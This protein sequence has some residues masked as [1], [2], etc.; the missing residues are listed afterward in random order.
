MLISPTKR[1]RISEKDF[2]P[3]GD[4]SRHNAPQRTPTTPIRASYLSPTKS[5][6]ARSHPH[7]VTRSARYSLTEPR[8]RALRDEVLKR[9][10]SNASATMDALSHGIQPDPTMTTS[11]G[12]PIEPQKS[13]SD[14]ENTAEAVEQLPGLQISDSHPVVRP[15]RPP[16][17]E[18]QPVESQTHDTSD[19]EA[20]LLPQFIM[21][22]L[23][24]RQ[25]QPAPATSRPARNEPDLP[26]TPVQLG[27]DPAPG[28]PK[29]LASSS[30]PRG[31]RSGSGRH[32]K[33]MRGDQVPGTSSPL[34]F[35]AGTR[36]VQI[37]EARET[38][39]DVVVE[40]EGER[41][42]AS[43]VIEESGLEPAAE[44]R[45][46]LEEKQRVL[47]ILQAQLSE[48]KEES[49]KLEA[50]VQ[51]DGTSRED[52]LSLLKPDSTEEGSWPPKFE[53]SLDLGD[54]AMAYLTL[55]AP[56]NVRLSS[57]TDTTN[58]GGRTK[59]VHLLTVT[60][61]P[62]WP[63][64]VFGAVLEVTVDA[65]DARV[66]KIQCKGL[67]SGRRRA[68]TAN[69]ALRMWIDQRLGSELHKL[70]VGGLIWSI[71]QYFEQC[72]VRA[73]VL[74]R[75][76]DR[77]NRY[78]DSEVPGYGDIEEPGYGDIEEPDDGD[79]KAPP[80]TSQQVTA[81]I[82]YLTMSQ[83]EIEPSSSTHQTGN[84]P[85]KVNVMLIWAI[86]FDWTGDVRS[87]VE[88]STS[89]ASSTAEQGI[90]E[91]F[92]RLVASEGVMAAI[93]GVWELVRSRQAED[94]AVAKGQ[95]GKRRQP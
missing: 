45:D 57:K 94:S 68:S 80:L 49:K 72:V 58:I 89:G 25:G 13:V 53:V 87:T 20:Q 90:K 37:D 77:Y 6:L 74:K 32:R 67:F 63:A 56:G 61:P 79:D 40:E 51:S 30:S 69:N 43:G 19:S 70:D 3:V 93:H 64:H 92:R 2:I 82:P 39:S 81:L 73:R 14:V 34:K 36:N 54:H 42:H 21:P 17:R 50:A 60:A 1:R 9:N 83:L 10:P 85:V 75:I 91:V 4:E 7:L 86:G 78:G 38:E 48:L 47:E 29:G 12:S 27:L 31:S 62:P 28:R 24:Q 35:K 76:D 44:S 71:G 22:K 26:P 8:G 65:K 41:D 46:E 33:R 15:V 66:E 5:S 95:K 18:R 52:I 16:L 88:I 84:H 23:V 11:V 59:I 55:F